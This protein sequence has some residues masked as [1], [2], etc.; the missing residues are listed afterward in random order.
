[1]S[2]EENKALVRKVIGEIWTVHKL[3][4]VDEVITA[5]YIF[6]GTGG[7]KLKGPEDYKGAFHFLFDAFPDLS[8]VIEDLIAEDDKVVYRN[9]VRGTHK[10]NYLGFA[11]TGKQF[12]VN[13]YG[14]VRMKDGKLA[15]EW[16]GM[17]RFD[18][19]QQLGVIPKE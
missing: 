19:V 13:E 1:M 15:E 14:I 16:G 8:F 11:P 6:H 3:T 17:D 5:D 12:T 9:T 4:L 2:I 7:L 10:G 18:L